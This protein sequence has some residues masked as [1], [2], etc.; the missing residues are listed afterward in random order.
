MEVFLEAQGVWDA[1][2]VGDVERKR[3]RQ[4]LSIIHGT[5]DE[6]TLL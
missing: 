4:V 6:E 1:I 3:D 5:I 2:E